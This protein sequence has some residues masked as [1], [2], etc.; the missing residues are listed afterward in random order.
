[1]TTY[2]SM[3]SRLVWLTE[4]DWRGFTE[5]VEQA[6][7]FVRY[8]AS[9]AWYGPK[10]DVFKPTVLAKKPFELEDI[11]KD[12]DINGILNP[13]WQ[14]ADHYMDA[15][16]ADESYRLKMPFFSMRPFHL[17]TPERQQKWKR[18]PYGMITFYSLPGNH[19]HKLISQRFYR[20][21]NKFCT[22]RNQVTFEMPSRKVQFIHEKGSMFWFG[23]D[24]IRWLNEDPER[25]LHY[26]DDSWALRLMDPKNPPAVGSTL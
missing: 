11:Y 7:P 16:E 26:N 23:H 1:M 15:A 3:R 22:N 25:S 10:P 2:A 18:F 6:F 24:A 4:G 20:L 9:I 14:P 19:E 12:E 17:F 5:A 8:Y 21:L 13:D